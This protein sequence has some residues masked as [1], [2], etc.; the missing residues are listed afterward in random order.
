[1]AA[2]A[3]SAG[4][5]AAFSLDS[6][7]TGD[8][9]AG[10]PADERM[11]QAASRRGYRLTSR[12]R[13]VT[14]DDFYRFDLILA[15]DAD[16][17]AALQQLRPED[18]TAEV[19]RFSEVTLGENWDVPDPYYGGARGFETVLDQLERGCRALLTRDTEAV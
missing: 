14:A 9:H 7:G 2:L 12:A 5:A 4:Q 13:Q 11:Q 18:A 8:W 16:N 19:G 3:A 1:M 6:A 17:L 10:N 15:M